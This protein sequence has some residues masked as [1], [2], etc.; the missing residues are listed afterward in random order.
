MGNTSYT[1]NS[2]NFSLGILSALKTID[3]SNTMSTWWS[4]TVMRGFESFLWNY[5]QKYA[6]LTFCDYEANQLLTNECWSYAW[7]ARPLYMLFLTFLFFLIGGGSII[8]WMFVK[9]YMES[10]GVYNEIMT[11]IA[12]DNAANGWQLTFP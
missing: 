1:S 2:S 5:V 11:N 7:V 9:D 3:L 12:N 10:F 6:G 8:G 4:N